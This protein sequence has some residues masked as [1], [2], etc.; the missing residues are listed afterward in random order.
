MFKS[1][2]LIFKSSEHK[3]KSTGLMFK[4]YEHKLLLAGKTFIPR[5]RS[6][7]SYVSAYTTT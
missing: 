7:F 4:T 6:S 1:F 3:F 2:E 5:L